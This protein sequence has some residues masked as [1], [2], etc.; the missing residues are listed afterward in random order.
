MISGP[1]APSDSSHLSRDGSCPAKAIVVASIA[2]EY[3][4]MEQHYPDFQ[5]AI[6]A[7]Q[8][9]D[10]NPLDV[11]TLSNDCGET[12]TVYFDISEFFGKRKKVAGPPC[13][14][15]GAPLRSDKAKQCFKCGM[16][17]HD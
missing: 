11:M 5:L 15:C 1:D 16:D 7:L 12:R 2:D 3:A 8:E 14:Y 13:P 4:W 10:G 9:I 17:W 6:Q